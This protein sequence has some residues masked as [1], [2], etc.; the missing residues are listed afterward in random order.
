MEELKLNAKTIHA[1]LINPE[2]TKKILKQASEEA[3]ATNTPLDWSK[4]FEKHLN[5]DDLSELK[6]E[7]E[8]KVE[9][10]AKMILTPN[11]EPTQPTEPETPPPAIA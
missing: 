2:A 10:I 5:T 8:I 7:K 11:D 1:L 4:Y 9:D 6:Q 3:T